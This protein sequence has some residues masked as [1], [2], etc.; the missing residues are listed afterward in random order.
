MYR[1]NGESLFK[2]RSNQAKGGEE[3]TRGPRRS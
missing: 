2:K 1:P 3:Y